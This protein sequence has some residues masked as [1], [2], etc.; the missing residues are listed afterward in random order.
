[1]VRDRGTG[2][3]SSWAQAATSL[4]EDEAI[5]RRARLRFLE[6]SGLP[7]YL[8]LKKD[9]RL[10]DTRVYAKVRGKEF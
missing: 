4:E 9:G 5:C 8:T 3:R 7:F 1:M 10:T 6:R 2:E